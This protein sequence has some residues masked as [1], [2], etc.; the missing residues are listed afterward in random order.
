MFCFYWD[1]MPAAGI[2]GRSPISEGR[3]FSKAL[4]R[5]KVRGVSPYRFFGG[6]E[7]METPTG[8]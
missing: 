8:A 6:R 2:S 5:L 1:L 7:S 4:I 3:Q